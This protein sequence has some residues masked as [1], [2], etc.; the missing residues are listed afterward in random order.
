MDLERIAD[1]PHG[2]IE[3]VV[4]VPA[5]RPRPFDFQTRLKHLKRGVL[6]FPMSKN[7]SQ[8]GRVA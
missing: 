8:L 2:E 5:F 1:G 3:S 4:A 7:I 6:V